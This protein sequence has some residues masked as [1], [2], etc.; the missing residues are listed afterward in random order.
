MQGYVPGQDEAFAESRKCFRE[1][2]D[3]MASAEAAGLQHGELEEQVDVR[4]RGLLLRLLQDRLDLTAAREER[5]RD[6]AGADGVV[7]TR[8]ERG[9][10]RPLITKFG[11]V[12]VSRIAYRSPGRPNVCPLDAA[13]NLPEEKH[14]HGLR[15]LAA[16]EAA[17]GSMEAAGAAITRATGVTIG[18]RQVEELARRCA[19]HVEAFYLQRVIEPAPDGWPLILTFDG[20]GIV[21]LPGALR[22]ATAKAAASAEGKLATR[23]SPGEKHGRKRMAELACVYDAAP[24]P[25]TP[26][27]IISTPAQ[28]RRKKKAQAKRPTGKGKPREPQAKGKWLTASVTDDIPAVIA[29]AFDEAGRRDPGHS[30]EWVVLIDGNNTQIEAVTAEAARRGVT[31]TIIIDFI[32]VLEYCWKAAWSFFDKGEPAAE[33]WV[34]DQARKILHGNARQVA[35]GIRRRATTCGY[36]GPERNTT[37]FSC[38]GSPGVL[39]SWCSVCVLESV[40]KWCAGMASARVSRRGGARFHGPRPG[41]AGAVSSFLACGSGLRARRSLARTR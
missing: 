11:H 30:R 25:R 27:D 32:H 4:G 19:A 9:R 37:D 41:A 21:M 20:K 34:A 31:V 22:P 23:L 17:R 18:K 10:E 35:A 8:A 29:A 16:V 36:S 12:T 26:E 1:L 39:S 6:V 13:L 40:L 28:K 15:K 38:L 3:W 5:R 24:V 2:E 7:R 14:S 33:E